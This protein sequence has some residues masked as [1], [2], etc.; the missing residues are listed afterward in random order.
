MGYL[1]QCPNVFLS[2]ADDAQCKV[3][4]KRCNHTQEK[5]VGMLVG[6]LE[7]ISFLSSKVVSPSSTVLNTV[8]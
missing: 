6:H 1:H 4:D 3:W 2:G 5:P 7:G 8:Q